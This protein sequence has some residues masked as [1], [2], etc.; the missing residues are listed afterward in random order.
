LTVAYVGTLSHNVPTMI[1][2]NYAPYSTAF[3]TPSTSATSV[4]NRRQFDPCVG[5][6]PTG[7]A[8]INTG[9]MGQN[10]YLITN[11]HAN[12]NALQVSARKQ[13]SHGFTIS[14]FYVW[15]RAL[16]SSNESAIGQMTAQDFGYLGGAFTATNN[17][18][19][20][21]GG[22]LAEEKGPMDANRTN[23]A[24]ISA[25][26]NID[27]F[28]GSSM[29]LKQAL[30]GWQIAPVLYMTSGAPLN[31]TTGSTKNFDSAGANRPNVVPGVNPK[32]NHGCRI[33]ATGSELT[34]WFNTA[35]FTN[36]GPGLPGGI[37][38][39]GADGNVTRDSILGPGF[40]DMDL[41]IFRTVSFE[42]GIAFQFRAEATNAL[43]WV[44]VGNPTT[45][46]SS[47]N[48]GKITGAQGT[49]RVIQLGGRLTF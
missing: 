49:Q 33:C 40:R 2:G 45:T 1:D 19:G 8:G 5:P 24:V 15:S 14:G 10:I 13:L 23:N 11:Q 22:G 27:Y 39:G 21:V 18:L 25:I 12:Y 44:S 3:G 17:T 16:Q 46:L 37:G 6:C 42:H 43:N 32:L 4:A 38:P 29:F 26:W 35:A 20:A 41:G 48:D 31:M 36:N 28:H 7:P 34:A 47:G 30:N 9:T